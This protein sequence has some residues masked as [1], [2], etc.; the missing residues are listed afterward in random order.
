MR[1]IKFRAKAI[2]G[3]WVYGNFI[4]SKRFEGCSNEFRIHN[5]VTGLESDIIIETLGEFIRLDKNGLEIYEGDIGVRFLDTKKVYTDGKTW[6]DY[7]LCEW[8]EKYSCFSTTMISNYNVQF[9][10]IVKVEKEQNQYS[11]RF[12]EIEI[13]GNIFDNQELFA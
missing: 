12:D 10:H 3:G 5:Q 11:K 1:I 4:H 6:R 9:G 7:W 8:L 2:S 13:V